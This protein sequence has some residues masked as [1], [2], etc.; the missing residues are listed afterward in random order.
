MTTNA[1]PTTEPATNAVT[2]PTTAVDWLVGDHYDRTAAWPIAQI[3]DSVH[4]DLHDVRHDDMLPATAE[5]TV[6]SDDDGPVPVLRVTISGLID[7]ADA[8]EIRTVDGS[9]VYA[10]MRTVFDLTNHYNR[11][12]LA[13]PGQA[14]FIQHIAALRADGAPAIVLIGM[15][16]DT[17][18]DPPTAQPTSTV[19]ATQP[20]PTA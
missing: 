3:A 1:T 11:V 15:M 6:S 7:T 2:T 20:V 10:C 16:H 19:T 4:Q 13:H 12:D 9:V 8:D 14:R 5:F 17:V 18:T